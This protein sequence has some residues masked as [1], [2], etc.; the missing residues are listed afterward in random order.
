M[1]QGEELSVAVARIEER[2]IA[3][4]EKIDRLLEACD[5]MDT[6]IVSLEQFRWKLAGMAATVGLCSAIV[7]KFVSKLIP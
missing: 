7:G 1:S 3:I 2:Q 4:A 5:D 6:R